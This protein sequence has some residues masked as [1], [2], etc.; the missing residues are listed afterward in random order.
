[1]R[2]NKFILIY[3][4]LWLGG[5]IGLLQAAN[6]ELQLKSLDT[7]D[8][9]FN[10]TVQG[11]EFVKSYLEQVKV[12]VA[13]TLR[14]VKPERTN[15]TD[16]PE[17]STNVEKK[18]QLDIFMPTPAEIEPV[19]FP[20]TL[21]ISSEGLTD[22]V[23]EFVFVPGQEELLYSMLQVHIHDIVEAHGRASKEEGRAS[24]EEG[25]ASKET[26]PKETASK[27]ENLPSNNHP[28]ITS[29]LDK[30]TP[31]LDAK[32]QIISAKNEIEL[33]NLTPAVKSIDIRLRGSEREQQVLD[34]IHIMLSE[35]LRNSRLSVIQVPVTA[36]TVITPA[37]KIY[38]NLEII[39]QTRSPEKDGLPY[40]VKVTLQ[41]V[42]AHGRASLGHASPPAQHQ[43]LEYDYDNTEIFYEQL[44]N[45]ISQYAN[46]VPR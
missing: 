36:D 44:R 41:E 45:Y 35:I 5:Q 18:W 19:A 42:E 37:I 17:S 12:M 4:A 31:D 9:G 20:F 6:G 34:D 14:D 11:T 24:K 26:T 39:I 7:S 28:Q 43:E 27:T 21:R 1:M 29:M 30:Q 32:P 22:S 25:R 40:P 2:L 10:I 23:Q 16:E 15:I 38:E 33:R 8:T 3:F 13:N 46:L